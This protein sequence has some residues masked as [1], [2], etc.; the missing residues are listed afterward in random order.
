MEL[1][2]PLAIIEFKAFEEYGEALTLEASRYYGEGFDLW[3][4]QIKL[5]F[6]DL[7]IDNMEIDP[8]LGTIMGLSDDIGRKLP[9][10]QLSSVQG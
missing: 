6:M 3:H 4:K 1:A 8:D 9:R 5:C 2:K 10:L 7:D